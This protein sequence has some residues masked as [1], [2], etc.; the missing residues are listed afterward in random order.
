MCADI[1]SF[2]QNLKKCLKEKVQ[3]GGFMS[4][5][6]LD[7][8]PTSWCRNNFLVMRPEYDRAKIPEKGAFSG[9]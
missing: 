1:P 5:T 4:I 3:P 8:S 7:G 6:V 2:V 9:G